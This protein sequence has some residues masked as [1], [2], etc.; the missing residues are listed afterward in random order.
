MRLIETDFLSVS[1]LNPFSSAKPVKSVVQSSSRILWAMD[2]LILD[3]LAYFLIIHF[4]NL[5]K[6][7]ELSTVPRSSRFS[8]FTIPTPM[9]NH[10][11]VLNF[12]LMMA[13]IS[14]S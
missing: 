7:V 1:K 4:S 9:A 12:F 8:D 3:E 10:D 14:V 5:V 13:F 6:T 2:S 11:T